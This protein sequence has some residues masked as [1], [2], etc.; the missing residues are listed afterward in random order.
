MPV[1]RIFFAVKT[2]ESLHER[3]NVIKRTWKRDDLLITFFSNVTDSSIP[4][5]DTGVP[6][7]ERGHCVK[8]YAILEKAGTDKKYTG[9]LWTMLVDDDTLISVGHL[10]R[11]LACYDPEE[12]TFLGEVYGYGQSSG[13]GYPYI[14]LGG[15]MAI[16][17]AGL[18]RWKQVAKSCPCPSLDT[19]DDMW[20]GN[21]LNGEGIPLTHRPEFH[22][23]RMQDFSHQY[24]EHQMAVSFHRHY[25]VDFDRLYKNEL[26][27]E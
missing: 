19:P 25:D 13:Y 4:T 14:T 16:S 21:C 17:R 3:L 9:V 5:V 8:S 24:L 6:N 15:G 23:A 22:Q 18:K 11:L 1:N 27:D 12:V 20:I 26:N 7:V 2:T 10:Q